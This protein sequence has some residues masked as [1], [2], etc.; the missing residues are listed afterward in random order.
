MLQGLFLPPVFQALSSSRRFKVNCAFGGA[1]VDSPMLHARRASRRINAAYARDPS[2]NAHV[3]SAGGYPH[4]QINTF[5]F[6]YV[7]LGWFI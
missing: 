1:T 3:D 7:P 4:Y 5:N 6:T 2:T